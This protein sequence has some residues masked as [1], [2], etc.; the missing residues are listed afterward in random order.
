MKKRLLSLLLRL[1]YVA[2]FFG[3]SFIKFAST[4]GDVLSRNQWTALCY[5]GVFLILAGCSIFV[6]NIFKKRPAAVVANS[7]TAIPKIS[8]SAIK[9][10]DKKLSPLTAL[11]ALLSIVWTLF[12]VF[13]AADSGPY[14]HPF[15]LLLIA[16]L[17]LCAGAWK[18]RGRFAAKPAVKDSIK[19]GV[20]QK[21]MGDDIYRAIRGEQGD[22]LVARQLLRMRQR[23]DEMQDEINSLKAKGGVA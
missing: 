13:A 17:P 10:V 12:F 21:S 5:G 9:K 3:A 19:I 15:V 22:P 23:M 2:V 4:N 1:P 14:D 20:M 16:S 11:L 18:Y 8:T 7:T 6:F